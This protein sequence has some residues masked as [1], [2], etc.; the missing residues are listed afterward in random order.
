[1]YNIYPLE[2]KW[3]SMSVSAM[4]AYFSFMERYARNDKKVGNTI[5]I[6]IMGR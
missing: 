1:M 5:I 6:F 3:L 4:A 2:Y